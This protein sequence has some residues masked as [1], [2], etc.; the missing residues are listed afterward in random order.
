MK[1]HYNLTIR[2]Q[3]VLSLVILI[4]GFVAI[5]LTYHRL[6]IIEKEAIHKAES[7]NVF[8]VLVN[9]SHLL[10]LDARHLESELKST[11]N[12]SYAKKHMDQI[13]MLHSN[14]KNL[15]KSAPS[16]AE[17]KLL[18][19]I[20]DSLKAYDAAFNSEFSVMKTLGLN[21]TQGLTAEIRNSAHEIDKLIKSSK[22]SE[23]RIS[24]FEMISQEKNYLLNNDSTHFESVVEEGRNFKKLVTKAKLPNKLQ[25]KI[26]AA[27]DSYQNLLSS[28]AKTL[29][30]RENVSKILEEKTGQIKR[31]FA[32]MVDR[33]AT[34]VEKN[35]VEL[36]DKKSLMAKVFVA[37]LLSISLIVGT[38]FIL[39]MNNLRFSL[40]KLSSTMDQVTKGNYEARANLKTN[41]ELGV[42]SQVFDQM[43]D[44]RF[45]TLAEAQKQND[46]LNDSIIELLEAVS[47]LSE[48]DLTVTVPIAEDVTGAVADSINQMAQQTATVLR[49]IN[50]VAEQVE[51]AAHKVRDQGD[52]VSTVATQERDIVEKTITRLQNAAKAM[53]RISDHAHMC[54]EIAGKASESTDMALDA[55][56]NT[57][58]GITKIR[59]TISETEKRIKRLGE[60][61]QEING[62][63]DIIN[64][65]AERTHVLALNA[66]MQA[67]AAGDAGRGFSVVADEVQRLAE[68]SRTST[69]KIRELINSIQ[70][71]TSETMATMNKA[72]SQ[73]VY[74]SE[75]AEKAGK[76]MLDTQQTTAKLVVTVGE[77]SEYSTNQAKISDDIRE[78]ALLIKKS[79]E[80]TREELLEQSTQTHKLIEYSDN[81]LKSVREFKLPAA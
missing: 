12:P 74:G 59:E 56:N 1:W 54:N 43:L 2:N 11:R 47:R 15:E 20:N 60:R 42:L 49:S 9:E 67:A 61:S 72:I 10:L 6:V 22:K 23:L 5:G 80:E 73:V 50:Q 8:E 45:A 44:D 40:S 57:V 17:K 24:L 38:V 19:K 33:T 48:K 51:Q 55:V 63:V 78:R 68:N 30:E 69:S 31:L 81:M 65:V 39:L 77:I 64:T 29:G 16:Q 35:Y 52:K 3:L 75:L 37:L 4:V 58:T 14:I 53:N 62:I 36:A 41:D 27:T 25:N 18:K 79:T 66:S 70:G 26:L 21:D 28:F 13:T 46:Q 32:Q 76:Q 7:L 71:E 34:I